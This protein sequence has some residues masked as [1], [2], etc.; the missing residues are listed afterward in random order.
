MAG[1][2]YTIGAMNKIHC[3]SYDAIERGVDFNTVLLTVIFIGN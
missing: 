2:A 3:E 1:I